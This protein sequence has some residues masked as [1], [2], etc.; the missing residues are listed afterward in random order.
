MASTSRYE[1]VDEEVPFQAE[2]RIADEIMATVNMLGLPLKLDQL[3]KNE[4]NCFLV[5]IL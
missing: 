2:R 1:W 3:T 4:G 5:A